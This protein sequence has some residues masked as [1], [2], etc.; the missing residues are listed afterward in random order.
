MCFN[1]LDSCATATATHLVDYGWNFQITS[2]NSAKVALEM[3]CIKCFFLFCCQLISLYK[4]TKV[5]ATSS[6]GAVRIQED[7]TVIIVSY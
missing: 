6:L 4:A 1:L 3:M 2:E 5:V 7:R